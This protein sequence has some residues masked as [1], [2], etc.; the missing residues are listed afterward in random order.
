MSRGEDLK[1]RM[2][3]SIDLD[4]DPQ[5]YK[6]RKQQRKQELAYQH[7]IRLRPIDAKESLKRRRPYIFEKVYDGPMV[8][9]AR[10]SPIPKK[11]YKKVIMDEKFPMIKKKRQQKKFQ[12]WLAELK[13]KREEKQK[14]K[15]AEMKNRAISSG[16][17]KLDNR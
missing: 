6:M 13:K 3:A 15:R 17:V 2:A 8:N 7:D 1:R 14:A 16:K 11:P 9:K 12:E 10:Q 5:D 4:E